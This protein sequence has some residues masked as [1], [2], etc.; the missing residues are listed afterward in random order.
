MDRKFAFIIN[1]NAGVKRRKDV[2]KLISDFFP[3]GDL[4]ELLLWEDKN[5]FEKVWSKVREKNFTHVVAV[6]GDGTVNKVASYLV[7]TDYV[8]GILPIGS[9]NGL[10]RSLG[11][12]MNIHLALQFLVDGLSQKMDVGYLNGKPFFCTAGVGFDATIGNAFV[13]SRRR[14]LFSYVKIVIRELLRYKSKKYHLLIDGIRMEREAFLITIANAGQY[15]NDFYIAPEAD[16]ADGFF[17][18]V[19][20]KPFGLLGF[21][22][23]LLKVVSKK[24]HTSSYVET[25]KCKEINVTS[26]NS[27]LFHFDGEPSVAQKGILVNIESEGLNVVMQ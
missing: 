14:G 3:S 15:G 22:S 17:H 27:E 2:R 20:V 4:Y 16:V 1:P 18:L 13:Q 26:I 24:A 7:G 11:V 10:A 9:G 21:F 6:G 5:N 19:I 8:L 12:P 23:L 25:V